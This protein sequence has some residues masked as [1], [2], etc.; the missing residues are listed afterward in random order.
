[1]MW[2]ISLRRQRLPAAREPPP[3]AEEGEEQREGEHAGA[4]ESHQRDEEVQPR[5]APPGDLPQRQE[6]PQQEERFG[7]ADLEQRR[8]RSGGEEHDGPEGDLVIGPHADDPV[9]HQA[10]QVSGDERDHQGARPPRA[11]SPAER[12]RQ[13]CVHRHE[14]PLVLG[15]GARLRPRQV[16]RVAVL[17]QEPIPLRVPPEDERHQ[18][19]LGAEAR[20]RRP[21]A[22]RPRAGSPWSRG[23]RRGTRCR[24]PRPCAARLGL[25]A[26]VRISG[27]STTPAVRAPRPRSARAGRA[28]HRG[29]PDGDHRGR[30]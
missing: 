11:E 20:A 21:T 5:V 14:R 19:R 2:T 27:C 3:D 23:A 1:M 26:G 17:R 7:V 25:G 30:S 15:H 9:Q 4:G 29:G 12:L 10:C 18:R 8:Q 13:I 16:D 28:P 6:E 24:S 22:V